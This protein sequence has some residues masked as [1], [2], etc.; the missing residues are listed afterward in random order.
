MS[1][2]DFSNDYEKD[3]FSILLWGFEPSPNFEKTYA[4]L[5]LTR[6]KVSFKRNFFFKTSDK[7]DFD[8]FL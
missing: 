5:N 7:Y 6:A 1:L 2:D 3:F 4:I 8:L